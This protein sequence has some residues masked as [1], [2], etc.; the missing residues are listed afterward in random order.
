MTRTNNKP[1]FHR[2]AVLAERACAMRASPTSTEQVL[3]QHIRGRRLGD[4]FRRQVPL[5]GRFSAD[6]AA[7]ARRVLVEV[8]GEYHGERAAADA[9]RFA[10]GR[11][12]HGQP[13]DRVLRSQAASRAGAQSRGPLHSLVTTAPRRAKRP[14]DSPVRDA[15]Q[16]PSLDATSP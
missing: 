9:R 6:F 8:D 14:R 13:L 10:A 5:L 15:T 1:S 4:V 16:L 11:G 12:G 2:A 7:P 3:W